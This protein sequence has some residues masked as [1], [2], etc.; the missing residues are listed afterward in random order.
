[1][2]DAHSDTCVLVVEDDTELR[3]MYREWLADEYAVRTAADGPETLETFD[4]D[5]DVVL[6]DRNLPNTTGEKLLPH[7]RNYEGECEIA[8][9]TAVEPDWDI[10]EMDFDAYV[11]KPVREP[12]LLDLVDALCSPETRSVLD[13]ANLDV[14]P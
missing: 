7:F 9:V 6:L 13:D 1:M 8:L 2:P 4:A 5:V 14:I 11:T 3:Q 12:N 10:L